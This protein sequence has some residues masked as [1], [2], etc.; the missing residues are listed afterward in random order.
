[1]GYSNGV[2]YRELIDAAAKAG[3]YAAAAKLEQSRNEKIAAEG[4]DY[5]PTSQYAAYLEEDSGGSGSGSEASAL[6]SRYA[7]ELASALSTLNSKYQ[8]GAAALA[9]ETEKIAPAYYAA[10]NRTAGEYRQAEQNW[11]EYAAASGLNSGASGQAALTRSGV[12]QS[13]MAALS[14]AEAE[15]YAGAESRRKQLAAE[16]AAAIEQARS[17]N[18]ADLAQALYE[19]YVRQDKLSYQREQDALEQERKEQSLAEAA[20][21]TR[22][23]RQVASA[24]ALADTGDFSAYKEVFGWTDAQVA[25]AEQGYREQKKK[26]S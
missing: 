12:Y 8:S 6:R 1:M 2:N 23:S 5:R 19:E 11:N 10:R 4:L 9:A 3:N 22:Y 14:A 21:K 26:K 18:S 25:A 13:N 24:E 20:E 7:S 17:E 16:Y 15:D